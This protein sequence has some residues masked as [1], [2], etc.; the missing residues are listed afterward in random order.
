MAV[1]REEGDSWPAAPGPESN[2]RRER[3]APRAIESHGYPPAGAASSIRS[4]AH[5]D[6]VLVGELG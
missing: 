2:V 3:S 5:K 6:N 4:I 1:V